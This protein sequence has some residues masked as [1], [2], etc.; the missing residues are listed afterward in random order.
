MIVATGL[1]AAGYEY[2]LIYELIFISFISILLFS[3]YG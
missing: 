2:G 3:E 1:A